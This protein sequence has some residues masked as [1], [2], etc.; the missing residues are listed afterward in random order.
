M[1]RRGYINNFSTTLDG[2]ILSSDTSIDVIDATGISSVLASSDFIML[3]IDDG[4]NIEIVKVTNVS[5]NTLTVVRAQ[6]NTSAVGFA[7]GITIE[8][9][10]TAA[11]LDGG[12]DLVQEVT[13]TGSQT[14]VAFVGLTAGVYDIELRNV[15]CNASGT[16]MLTMK[17]G[18]GGT[19]TYQSSS[20]SYSLMN[21]ADNSSSVNN[22]I[23]GATT[24]ITLWD[25][26]YEDNALFNTC[27]H[28]R[29]CDLGA[30]N[31]KTFTID[32]TQT[33]SGFSEPYLNQNR[34]GSAAWNDS[35]A[36]TAIKLALNNSGV[37]RSGGK[38]I[39]RKRR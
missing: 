16:T 22:V 28:I 27:G 34:R 15:S 29:T 11:S 3:T 24:Y 32:I 38:A 8:C 25:A 30:S 20:Y 33:R 26:M 10:M 23:P 6:E 35:T 12:W 2:S 13:F 21:S 17:V 14:N 39:L 1:I 36:V 19:P 7:S 18:T 37:F 9:R 5:T 31:Y 4:T